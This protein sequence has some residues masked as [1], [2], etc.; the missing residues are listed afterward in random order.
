MLEVCNVNVDL[1]QE[2][3]YKHHEAGARMNDTSFVGNGMYI[4]R[5]VSDMFWNNW[6]TKFTEA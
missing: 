5:S 2:T 6:Q 1:S 3:L 4:K